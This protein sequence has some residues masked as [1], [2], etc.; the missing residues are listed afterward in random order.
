[1]T[2]DEEIRRVINQLKELTER[3]REL[4][5][6]LIKVRRDINSPD[7]VTCPP[8]KPEPASPD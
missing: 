5:D 8:N 2:R 6:E 3:V 4:T 7:S 1:M